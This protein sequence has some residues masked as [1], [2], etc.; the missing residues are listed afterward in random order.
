MSTIPFQRRQRPRPIV[1]PGPPWKLVSPFG[2]LHIIHD[3]AAL[4]TFTGAEDLDKFNVEHLL[5]LKEG[6]SA[7]PLHVKFWQPLHLLLFLRR[8]GSD[9]LVPV[10]G[11]PGHGAR[12]GEAGVDHFIETVAA[13]RDDMPFTSKHRGKLQQILVGSYQSNGKPS[14]S[15]MKWGLAD[16]PADLDGFF[17]GVRHW[18]SR[19]V[20]KQACNSYPGVD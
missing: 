4:G 14:N 7:R 19:N 15:Y 2:L 3:R 5:G 1:P 8:D 18:A 6:S 9:E 20:D 16:P 10:L 17:P 11:G 12:S 13:C